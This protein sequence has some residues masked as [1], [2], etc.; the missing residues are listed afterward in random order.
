MTEDKGIQELTFEEID[1]VSGAGWLTDL[2]NWIGEHVFG[3]L[4]TQGNEDGVTDAEGEI[5][6]KFPF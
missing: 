3:F 6:V 5:G 1:A 4:N 2:V